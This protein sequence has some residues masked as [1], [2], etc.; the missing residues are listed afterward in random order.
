MTLYAGCNPQVRFFPRHFYP[1]YNPQC[2]FAGCNPQ[3]TFFPKHF[4]PGYNPHDELFWRLLRWLHSTSHI[5][6]SYRLLSYVGYNPRV[7]LYHWLSCW[8]HSTSPNLLSKVTHSALNSNFGLQIS[9]VTIRSTQSLILTNWLLT[10]SEPNTM[11]A[12][13]VIRYQ[14]YSGLT[15]KTTL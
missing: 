12:S 7:I 14:R 9:P 8:L 4:Y 6:P 2:S 13:L 3:I 1:G 10:I 11:E 15:A 5:F